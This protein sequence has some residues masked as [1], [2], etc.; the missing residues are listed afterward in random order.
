MNKNVLVSILLCLISFAACQTCEQ[1]V[2][3]LFLVV[4]SSGSIGSTVFPL[5]KSAVVEMINKLNII[6]PQKI[7]VG[8]INYSSTIQTITSLVDTDQDKARIIANVNNMPYLNQATA[9]GNALKVARQIFS[10]Y[11]RDGVPRV[12][13]LF[14]D[15]GSN[16]GVSVTSEA[17]ELKNQKISIFTVGIGSQ[18]NHNEL[19]AISSDPIT[20]YKKLIAN[21][22]QLYAAINEITQ[23]ACKTPAFIVVKQTVF[24]QAVEKNEPRYYQVD[25]TKLSKAAGDLILIELNTITGICLVEGVSWLTSSKTQP[26]VSSNSSYGVPQEAKTVLNFYEVVPP[27]A[28]R[29]Y[30]NVKCINTANSYK[31]IIDKF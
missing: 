6:G 11:P 16:E 24:A 9:T 15:G 27:N 29:L 3:D 30:V 1:R 7:R 23:T 28:L 21:Y 20:T 19:N 22:Q 12:L 31:F 4:D 25:M 13:V 8:V 18:I 10:T 26:I 5:A 2:L 17:V 14:T